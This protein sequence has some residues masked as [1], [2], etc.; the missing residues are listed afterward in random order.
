[1]LKKKVIGKIPCTIKGLYD[2]EISE[3]IDDGQVLKWDAG[4]EKWINGTGSGGGGA[5]GTLN[6]N[7][8]ASQPVPQSAES[9]DSNIS[10]HKIAKTGS[11]NDLRDKPSIPGYVNADWDAEEGDPGEILNK[12]D[13]V[14]KQSNV[15]WLMNDGSVDGVAKATAAD[16][17]A[18]V[19]RATVAEQELDDVKANKVANATQ[20]HLAGL[21]STGDLTDSGISIATISDMQVQINNILAEL[22]GIEMTVTPQTMT[23]GVSNSVSISVGTTSATTSIKVY[24]GSTQLTAS[25][26]SS[27]SW[28]GTDTYTP[29]NTN[30]ITYKAVVVVSG[31]TKER[32]VTVIVQKQT[33]GLSWSAGSA[34][35]VLNGSTSGLPTLTK[36]NITA[37]ETIT[38]TSSNTGVATINSSGVVT[39]VGAG[40]TSITARYAGSTTKAS[41]SSNYILTVQEDTLVS[42]SWSGGG[43]SPQS[44]QADSGATAT[45]TKGTV[46]AQYLSGTTVDVTNEPGTEFFPSG[47]TLSGTTYTPPSTAGV[48]YIGVRYG[49]QT[50]RTTIGIEVT[51][52]A[53]PAYIGAGASVNAVAVNANKTTNYGSGSV[54]YSVTVENDGDYIYFLLPNGTP[55]VDIYIGGMPAWT[56]QL[57]NTTIN[58]VTYM[59]KRTAPQYAGS[60]EVTVQY[61]N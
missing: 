32:S 60:R 21:D 2:T 38:Y 59:V 24:R 23:V 22:T 9:F 16:L 39:L 42:L 20:G 15:G 35:A 33:T 4:R 49:G 52:A 14:T 46:T 5:A 26:S 17:Q 34:T 3:T 8:T 10:L 25:S 18:E 6:T 29:A 55:L 40:T 19:T 28:S 51:A 57:S 41:S 44:I 31:V 1:M 36:T 37:G 12:P 54:N 43:I 53:P 30:N 47:G 13:V 45:L 58:G 7:N 56:E 48:Y 11:Y 27:T 61:T 50:A